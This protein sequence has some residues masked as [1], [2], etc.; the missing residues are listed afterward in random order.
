MIN[1]SFYNVFMRSLDKRIRF[2]N[3]LYKQTYKY[4]LDNFKDDLSL[5]SDLTKLESA[6]RFFVKRKPRF[7]S[8]EM[9]EF[10]IL[11]R[12]THIENI[13][14][15]NKKQKQKQVQA[16]LALEV[17]AHFYKFGNFNNI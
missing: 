16:L 9:L 12:K 5:K 15:I 4:S 11:I 1:N 3:D 7:S 10:D 8:I 2:I 6:K 13:N 14:N 17:L